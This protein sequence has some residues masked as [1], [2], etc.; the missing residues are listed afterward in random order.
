MILV[1]QPT[2]S[3]SSLDSVAGSYGCHFFPA[4]KRNEPTA[5]VRSFVVVLDIGLELPRRDDPR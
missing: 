3:I 5:P 1:N 2:Q 4:G